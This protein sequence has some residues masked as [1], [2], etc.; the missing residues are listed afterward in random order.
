MTRVRLTLG[1][2]AAWLAAAGPAAAF[3]P[4][5]EPPAFGMMGLARTQWALLTAVLTQPP[6]PGAPACEMALSFV[7]ST[8]RLLNDAAGNPLTR[9]VSLRGN[10]AASLQVRSQDVIPDG[11][12]RF[13]IRGVVQPPDPGQPPD[14]QCVGLV[15]TVE[16][17]DLLGATRVLAVSQ[18]H[19]PD[20]LEP[21]GDR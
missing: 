12:L 7:D 21:E 11:Q 14:P 15:A 16:I 1:L 20:P 17:V 19:P 2:G 9:R 10:V 4:Q 5:P 8:G 18:I 13:A 6:D 3:N